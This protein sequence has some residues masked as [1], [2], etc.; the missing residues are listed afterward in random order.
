MNAT[1]RTTAPAAAPMVVDS[2]AP[3]IRSVIFPS[4]LEPSTAE[5]GKWEGSGKTIHVL[6]NHKINQE[7]CN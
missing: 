5:E 1:T 4:E 7:N 3:E 6:F 2:A